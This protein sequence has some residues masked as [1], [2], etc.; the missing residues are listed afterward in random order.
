M[1]HGELMLIGGAGPCGIKQIVVTA[2]NG[3]VGVCGGG[4]SGRPTDHG[5][6]TRSRIDVPSEARGSGRPGDVG[7]E[8]RLL[9]G[10]VGGK[11]DMKQKLLAL[12][13]GEK[14]R[15]VDSMDRFGLFYI[16]GLENEVVAMN[17]YNLGHK[18]DT[19]IQ[20]KFRHVANGHAGNRGSVNDR[21]TVVKAVL[22]DWGATGAPDHGGSNTN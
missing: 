18:P 15:Q 2:N 10:V 16:E 6:Q 11:K 17:R 8:M 22:G 7:G 19:T 3:T 12:F 13:N 20:L 4:I 9:W 21:D 5:W 1:E 14:H